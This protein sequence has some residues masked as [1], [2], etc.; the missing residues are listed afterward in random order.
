MSLNKKML[1]LGHAEDMEYSVILNTDKDKVKYIKRVESVI[2]SSLEY[3]EYID[4][5][6]K[7]IGLDSCIFFQNVTSNAGKGGRSKV[8]IEIH[9]EPL[10]LF[11]IT[12]TI[13]EKFKSTGEPIN[14]LAIAE[15]VMQLHYE[16]KVGLVPVSKTAHEMVH[17]STKLFVPLTMVYGEYSKFLEEYEEWI[18]DTI[19]E[20]LQ[21]KQELT[22]KITPDTFDA[23][24][25]E[26]TYLDVDGVD[27]VKKMTL[28]AALDVA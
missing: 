2:R 10:T 25:R 11:D 1:K 15:E 28:E 26:F 16:N 8:H 17:N 14:D 7:F 5:L 27:D 13:Y 18:D 20:K 9:H 3:K 22:E 24:C 21:H 23:I 12:N 4:Y 6:K 19:Y